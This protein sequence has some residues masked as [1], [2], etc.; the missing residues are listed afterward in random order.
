MVGHTHPYRPSALRSLLQV[1]GTLTFY[2][3][4]WIA[5]LVYADRAFWF[6]FI[7]ACMLGLVTVRIFNIQHDCTHHSYFKRKAANDYLGLLL[8]VFTLTPHVYWTK[9][10][11]RHHGTAGDLDRRGFG[12][13]YTH[14]LQ[15]FEELPLWR[16]LSYILYRNP[17]V[18][19]LIG[20]IYHF[21]LKM[22]LPFIAPTGSGERRSIHLTN[23]ML[24]LLALFIFAFY[25]RP[26]D[27]F[28]L[29][30]VCFLVGGSVGLWLFYVQHQFEDT[31]WQRSDAW[32]FADAS[33]QG[34]SYLRM[35]RP[36]EWF[37]LSINLHHVH[38]LY[39][40]TPNYLLRA[41]TADL[42]DVPVPG[43]IGLI[44]AL[45]TFRLKL[46]D[47]EAGKMVGFPPFKRILA[48]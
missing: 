46:W 1:G 40:K 43:D 33:L 41:R 13:I 23:A 3:S 47:E 2:S 30:F 29:I 8:G 6:S 37:L 14:T 5:A 9:N 4:L 25:P 27:V 11:L 22:R 38:H 12:D 21:G 48:Q 35:P 45:R 7:L 34:S 15:E 32:S 18:Y 44:D 19:L 10:H 16:K 17:A 28:L 26:G 20:P 36:M 42:P 31:Y 24:A 39:P